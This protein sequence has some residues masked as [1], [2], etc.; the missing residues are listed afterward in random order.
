MKRLFVILS[1]VGLFFSINAAAYI[2]P[3]KMILSRTAEN[4]GNGIYNIDLE[5]AF[6]DGSQEAFVKETWSIE[7]ERTLRL[8]VQG[9]KDLKGLNLNFLYVGGQRWT[10]KNNSKDQIKISEDFLEKWH[11]FRSSD[12]FLNSLVAQ[13]FIPEDSFNKKDNKMKSVNEDSFV[14]LAR[15][16]GIVAYSIG[17]NK[18]NEAQ[19]PRFWIEQDF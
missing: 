2:P 17:D 11:H 19:L 8:T 5:V 1:M 13:N 7:N 16:Q 6:S 12:I 14:K 9:L 10:K 15:T 3:L 18:K 4:A